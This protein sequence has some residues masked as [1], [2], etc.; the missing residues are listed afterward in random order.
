MRTSF[1]IRRK[2][3]H[4]FTSQF[5]VV[6]LQRSILY[7]NYNIQTVVHCLHFYI[8]IIGRNQLPTNIKQQPVDIPLCPKGWI[9]FRE[10]CYWLPS[11]HKRMSWPNAERVCQEKA[12]YFVNHRSL[13]NGHLASVHSPEELQFLI[14]L[15]LSSSF[16]IGLKA[17]CEH[18]FLF[19]N[20]CL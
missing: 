5:S 18:I 2:S 10:N 19:Q 14:N 12:S 11:I 9:S 6:T 20:L 15:S 1:E 8:H 17:F 13:N 4:L 7:V 16:W 3:K